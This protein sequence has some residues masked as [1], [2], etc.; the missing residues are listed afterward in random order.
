MPNIFVFEGG[1]LRPVDAPG[2]RP[3]RYAAWRPDGALAL[4]AGNRGEAWTFDGGAFKR[5]ATGVTH[6]LRAV[7]W[8]PDGASA[9]LAGN[10]GAALHFDG[11]RFES[12]QTP[13]IENLRRAAWAPDGS[14]ALIIGNAGVVLRYDAARRVLEPLPGDRAHTLRSIAWRPDGAYALIGAYAS[15]YA[16]YPRPHMLYR[17]DGRYTQALLATDDDDDAVAVSWRPGAVPHRALVLAANAGDAGAANK[18]FEYDGQTITGRLVETPAELLGAAWSPDGAAA[19]LC[20]AHGTLIRYDGTAFV[21]VESGVKENLVGPFWHP[22]G[23]RALLLR[24]PEERVY[25]V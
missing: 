19:L 21:T 1:R 24:G 13:T 18:I 3:L 10:R 25:T 20:G 23:E 9:L 11:A 6:N 22:L 14:S 12:L 17:C 5:L 7:A 16:G 2:A 4:L 15:G 8:A